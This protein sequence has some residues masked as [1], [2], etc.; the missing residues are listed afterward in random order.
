MF[1]A[2]SRRQAASHRSPG[3]INWSFVG[4]GAQKP[5]TK[6]VSVTFPNGRELL[7]SYWGLLANGGLVLPEPQGLRE[8]D[9]VTLE[10]MLAS[11][12]HRYRLKGRVVR[13]PPHADD[14]PGTVVIAFDPGEPH[15]LLLS[16]AWAETENVPPRRQR[17]FP[18]D[19]DIRFHPT[20]SSSE[21]S[22]RLVNVSLGG[23]CLRLARHAEQ[24]NVNVGE[25]LT[26]ISRRSKLAGVVRWSEGSCRGIE[27]Q[28]G[29]EV[30]VEHFVNDLR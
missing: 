30:E 3:S 11:T 5:V 4:E 27:F 9:Q 17:R 18:L 1:L 28:A 14:V 13:K 15:D 12:E 19:V 6:V 25:N 2:A 8:G 7:A 26:L 16:A 24:G 21:L 20:E 22:G 23:C 10:V 29:N